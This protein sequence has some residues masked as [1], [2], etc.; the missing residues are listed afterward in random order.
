[1]DQDNGAKRPL[2]TV[3]VHGL[4]VRPEDC[5]RQPI[6]VVPDMT[7]EPVARET[8][9]FRLRAVQDGPEIFSQ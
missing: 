4:G 8:K 7:L 6:V 9:D 1:M 2:I 5:D 3:I